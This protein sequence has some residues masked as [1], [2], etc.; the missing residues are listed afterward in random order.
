MGLTGAI[1]QI[2]LEVAA[3]SRQM[4]ASVINQE[5]VSELGEVKLMLDQKAK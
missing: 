5:I 4:K 1:R 2:A 3:R